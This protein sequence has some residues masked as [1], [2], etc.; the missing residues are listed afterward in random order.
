MSDTAQHTLWQRPAWSVP[1]TLR[2]HEIQLVAGLLAVSAL[3]LGV[4]QGPHSPEASLALGCLVGMCVLAGWRRYPVLIAASAGALWVIPTLTADGREVAGGW[5]SV[6]AGV[7]T[8]MI[9]YTLG[10]RVQWRHSLVGLIP[11]TVGSVLSGGGDVN[12][13]L[14]MVTVGPWLVGLAIA[15]R[16]RA[17]AQLQRRAAELAQ[18]RELFAQES[19]RYDRARIARELHDLVAHGVSLI[20]VQANAGARLAA[21]DPAAAAESF[22]AIIDTAPYVETEVAQLF[23]LL[24]PVSLPAAPFDAAVIRALITRASKSGLRVSLSMNGDVS[25][26]TAVG[27]DAAHHLVEEALTNAIKHA[28]GAAVRVGLTGTVDR[29]EISV[30]NDPGLG[31]SHAL[32]IPGGSRGLR[33]LR[34]RV[35]LAGGILEAGPSA[36]GGWVVSAVLPQRTNGFRTLGGAES[37][38][39]KS[40]T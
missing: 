38:T 31:P 5:A 9:A 19:V 40:S 32:D 3:A 17:A 4:A 1:E 2:G 20:V 22:D 24:T 25:G 23:D 26:L 16:R 33:G 12:P 37:R 15:D 36:G 28:P 14:I 13:F 34:E 7:A 18:E 10:D 29:M 39:E 21:V 11:L 35:R 27:A 8:M 30:G 6:P